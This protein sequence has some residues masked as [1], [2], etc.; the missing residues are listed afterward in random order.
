MLKT[1]FD[2]GARLTL[3]EGTF[4]LLLFHISVKHQKIAV[5]SQFGAMRLVRA[6]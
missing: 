4:V 6:M 3:A 2:K 5:F 1:P